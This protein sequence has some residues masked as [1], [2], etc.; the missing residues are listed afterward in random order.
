MNYDIAN[1]KQCAYKMKYYGIDFTYTFAD[2]TEKVTISISYESDYK[3]LFQV[4]KMMKTIELKMIA[5]I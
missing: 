1:I 5:D 2:E 3:E 4:I